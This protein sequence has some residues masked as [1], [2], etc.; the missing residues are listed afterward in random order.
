MYED[1]IIHVSRCNMYL[2][3]G[4]DMKEAFEQVLVCM[5]GYMTELDKVD[6][7]ITQTRTIKAEGAPTPP[8]HSLPPLP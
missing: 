1:D 3:G 4:A 5:F 2:L 6:V 8:P 7:D